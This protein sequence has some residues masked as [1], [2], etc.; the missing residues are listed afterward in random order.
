MIY[1]VQAGNFVKCGYAKSVQRRI[2]LLQ[3]ANPLPI[4]ILATC[5]GSRALEASF[6]KMME[7]ARANGEWFHDSFEIVWEAVAMAKRGE[8]PET[9]EQKQDIP[10]E[11]R[12]YD[13]QI[14][15]ALGGATKLAERLGVERSRV[16]NW[17]SRGISEGYR[18]HV[19][20]LAKTDGV[21]IDPLS[22]WPAEI[23]PLYANDRSAA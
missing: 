16:S 4:A 17:L 13:E 3:T 15:R 9:F 22:F 7:I 20:Q 6:H 8:F 11:F 14:I 12:T 5:P 21:C 2:A 19:W 10:P 23:A 18:G 1:F